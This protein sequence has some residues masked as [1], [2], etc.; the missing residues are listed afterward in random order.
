VRHPQS[1]NL[2]QLSRYYQVGIVNTAF[3]YGM[4]ALFVAAGINMYLAQ[5]VAH[6]FG[7]AFNYIT[8]SRHVF[9]DASASKPRFIASYVLSY[10]LGLAA[11][12]AVSRLVHS[13]YLAGLAAVVFVSLINYFVLRHAVFVQNIAESGR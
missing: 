1:L 11:L 7:V 6:V 5:I 4:Y 10:L 12:A 8:Y 2:R 9:H 3:G 13:A